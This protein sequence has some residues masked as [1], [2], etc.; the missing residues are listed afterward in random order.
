MVER[1]FQRRAETVAEHMRSR[2]LSGELADGAVL[3][4]EEEL[5]E[6]FPVSKPTFRE[7]MRILESEGLVTVRRGNTGGAVVH[8]PSPR[9]VAYTLGLVMAAEQVTI[10][11]V[12]AALREIEP[13]C[14]ALCALRRDRKRAVV[15]EL[16]RLHQR[17]LDS[18]EHL[19]EVVG[20][21]R[22]FHESLVSLCGNAPLIVTAGAL[23]SMWSAHEKGWAS[24]IAESDPV[25]MAERVASGEVHQQIIDLIEVGDADTVRRV[26]AEHLAHAQRSPTPANGAIRVDP[27]VLR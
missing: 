6:L 23:E 25:Q 22:A 27:S 21:S 19:V 26:A 5:R 4:K 12:A 24:R 14:A 3:P 10:D 15:P 9:H 13:A 20:W 8:R 7:A 17:Y 11:H 16:R 18:I 2:I 1:G